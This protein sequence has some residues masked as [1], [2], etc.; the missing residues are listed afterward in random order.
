MMQQQSP[1][2]DTFST[3]AN[4]RPVMNAAMFGDFISPPAMMLPNARWSEQEQHQLHLNTE[5]WSSSILR[6]D[7]RLRQQ[8]EEVELQQAERSDQ[9][10][11]A[12]GLDMFVPREDDLAD[13]LD[14]SARRSTLPLRPFFRPPSTPIQV[15]A[16]CAKLSMET[17][18]PPSTTTPTRRSL[19]CVQCRQL[20]SSAGSSS[21]HEQQTTPLREPLGPIQMVVNR[22]FVCSN[23]N[24]DDINTPSDEFVLQ[25]PGDENHAFDLS[26]DSEMEDADFNITH[27]Q[28]PRRISLRPK[29]Q[30]AN[31][32][33][34]SSPLLSTSSSSS[35]I[36]E[37]DFVDTFE[38]N[39]D[40]VAIAISTAVDALPPPPGPPPAAAARPSVAPFLPLMSPDNSRPLFGR[41]ALLQ[42]RVPPVASYLTPDGL[43]TPC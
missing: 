23:N 31:R 17:P 14:F 29:M 35:I 20:A 15:C 22:Q 18:P 2:E 38:M 37:T 28:Q 27:E 26:M 10:I 5:Q 40:D 42:I 4:L 9:V 25:G 24:C 6:M 3:P 33:Q 11:S 32:S 30:L 1:R 13:V 12:A 16:A 39:N 34:S 41:G 7:Q 21:S 43:N 8:R 36:E 19:Q